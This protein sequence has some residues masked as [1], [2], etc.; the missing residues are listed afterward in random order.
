[1]YKNT[2]NGKDFTVEF[3]KNNPLQGSIDGESFAFDCKTIGKNTYHLIY[4]HKSYTIEMV[5]D[6]DENHVY[7]LKINN[8]LCE[9]KVGTPMDIL[10]NTLGISNA[11]KNVS[12]IKAPMPGMVLQIPVS[13]GE[14]IKK[15]DI[16]L[17]LEAMKMENS[18]KSPVDGVIKQ[19]HCT[20][21]KAVEKNQLLISFQ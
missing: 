6:I 13:V 9:V 16:L 8:K 10:L 19:I 3:D 17:I 18:L 5:Q 2:I 15:G 11:K 21:G 1:M 14:S 20:V 7:A 4:N 12:E